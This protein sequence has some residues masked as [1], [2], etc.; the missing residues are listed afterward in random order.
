METIYAS[1]SYR[2]SRAAYVTQCT[3]EYF[4]SL[5]CTD[6][7]LAKLLKHIGCSDAFTGVLSSV[8]SAAFLLQLFTVPLAA[9]LRHVKR[10]V[11]ALDTAS[12]LMF[13]SIYAVPFL[14]FGF[15]GKAGAAAALLLL[16]YFTFYV[17]QSIAYKWGNSFVSPDRRARFSAGKEM[18]SLLSGVGY[19]LALGFATDAFEAAGKLPSAFVFL[20]S[21]MSAVA[22]VN[23]ICFLRM[24]ELPLRSGAENQRFSEIF[25]HTF[26]NPRFRRVTFL[27]ALSAFAQSFA[28]G[29]AGTYKTQELG[30]SVGRMQVIN[31]AACLGRF[32]VSRPFGGYSDRAG[33]AKGYFL[34]SLLAAGSFLCGVFTAPGT[35]LLL[36]PLSVLYQIS[37]AGTNQNASLMIYSFVEND[38]ITQ[39]LAVKNAVCGASS[40]CAA[41]LGGRILAAVQTA[42][43]T[44]LG[45]T[46]YGQQLLY[47]IGFVLLCAALVYNRFA[48]CGK[49]RRGNSDR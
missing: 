1:E 29:F 21:V 34:G 31:T 37:L 38:Y 40:F 25:S 35:R 46:V 47:A 2:R 44:V 13:T 33:Y 16:G 15:G 42:G 8:A 11:T 14:P 23:L 9:R 10:T 43:N 48:V 6:V 32:A 24:Q 19:S 12:Q 20:G 5:S 36:I 22:A 39:A 41:L 45:R 26:R 28:G 27:C 18:V 7:Y 4:I 17:N 3:T 49:P 30:F